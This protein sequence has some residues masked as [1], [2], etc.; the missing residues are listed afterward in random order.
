MTYV[1]FGPDDWDEQKKDDDN[2]ED[3][4]ALGMTIQDSDDVEED[5]DDVSDVTPPAAAEDDEEPLDGLAALEKLEKELEVDDVD[6]GE[7]E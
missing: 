3:L 1:T 6:L 4:Q 7:D 2:E 5:A